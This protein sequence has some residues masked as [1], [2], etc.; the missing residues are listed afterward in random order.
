MKSSRRQI[1][2]HLRTLRK[3]SNDNSKFGGSTLR[4]FSLIWVPTLVTSRTSQVNTPRWALKNSSAPFETTVLPTV[5]L[6]ISL[7]IPVL[8]ELL[9]GPTPPVMASPNLSIHEPTRNRSPGD[10]DRPKVPNAYPG[11]PRPRTL[12][13]FKILAACDHLQ[14]RG[15]KG[16]KWRYDRLD[17]GSEPGVFGAKMLSG[18]DNRATKAVR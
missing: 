7:V 8:D 15:D 10:D 16:A 4:R 17:R 3:L 6:S 5:R 2:R 1:S 13:L 9:V 14:S 11:R 18:F 12:I